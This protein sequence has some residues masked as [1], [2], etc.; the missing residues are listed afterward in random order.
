MPQ[1]EKDAVVKWTCKMLDKGWIQLSKLPGGAQTMFV[2]KKT[3][4]M[5][6]C[7]D[8]C[9]LNWITKHDLF[10]LPILH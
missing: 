7:I 3:G 10:S 4:E 5:H 1:V 8:Y 6:L 9:E 2:P